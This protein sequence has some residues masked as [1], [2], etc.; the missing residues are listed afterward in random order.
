MMD[1]PDFAAYLRALWGRDPLPWQQMLAERVASG[2]W[3]Q[4]LDLPTASG[5]TACID[6]AVYALAAQAHRPLAER[7]AP[8]RIWFVDRRIVVDEAFERASK[9]ADKL[10]RATAGPLKEVADRLRALSGTERPLAV[11]RLRGGILRDD[12]WARIPSQPAV[13]TSTVDQVGS[14]LLFR[15]YWHSLLAAPIFAG[16]AANDS[17]IILDEAHCVVPSSVPRGSC[18]T[19]GAASRSW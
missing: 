14:R 12:G 3:P 10:A 13:I 17:L 16:L 2:E 6:I 9:I 18:G 8:R 15:G 1:A 5:K 11:G 4:A 19:A 7:T